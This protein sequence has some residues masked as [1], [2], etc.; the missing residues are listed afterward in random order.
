[1]AKHF[2]TV[3]ELVALLQSRGVITDDGTK[4]A[5]ERESYYAIVN[6][7]KKPFLDREAMAA[8]P[9]DVYLNGTRFEWIY[10]LFLFDRDLRFVTF[11]YLTRAEAIMRTA[12]AYAFSEAHPEKDAYLDRANYCTAESYLVPRK[13]KGNKAALHSSNLSDLMRR[14]NEKLAINRHTRPFIKHYVT[15]HG[16]VPLWV[17]ANDLTFGNIV[18]LYQLMQVNDR[19]RVCAIIA[20]VTMR[21]SKDRGTLSERKLLRAAN[22]LNHFRNI[23]AHDERLYCAKMGEDGYSAMMAQLLELLPIDEFEDFTQEVA[24]LYALYRER[25]HNMEFAD[26]LVEM[27]FPIDTIEVDAETEA[28]K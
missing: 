11:Q 10:D 18:H 7:Y 27:G 24:T 6:G 4:P 26:L 9:D 5:I 8:A 15:V 21:R 25:L 1:M 14:L 12:V 19:R 17:L 13:F 2:R 20:N 3:D 28:A 16:T 22:V 23:C